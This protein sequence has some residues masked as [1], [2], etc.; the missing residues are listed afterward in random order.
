MTPRKHIHVPFE[1]LWSMRIPVPY[2]LFLRAGDLGWSCGQCPL[3]R[4]GAVVAPDDG[5]AQASLVARH[6]SATL[7][8]AGMDEGDLRMAVIYHDL[9]DPDASFSILRAAFGPQVLMVPVACPAFYYPGM[10]IEVDLFAD[11]GDTLKFGPGPVAGVPVIEHH[12]APSRT[13]GLPP[14]AVIDPRL[15]AP[16]HWTVHAPADAPPHTLHT[17]GTEVHVR[18]AEGFL[19]LTA[20]APGL[21]GLVPQTEAVMSALEVALTEEGLSFADVVKSTTHYCG[22]PTPQDLHDNMAVRNRRYRAPGPASTGIR[23]SGLAAPG[24]LTAV[25]LLALR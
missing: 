23:V 9:P 4:N 1:T 15:P 11:R 14:H 3:D 8:K 22:D 20:L 6:A 18:R 2:S 5:P 17:G 16:V 10:R 25:S 24:A 19:G 12:A 7:R 21:A 13:P